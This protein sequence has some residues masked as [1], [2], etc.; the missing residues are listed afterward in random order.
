MQPNV[1]G[2]YFFSYDTDGQSLPGDLLLDRLGLAPIDNRLLE[3]QYSGMID[4][5]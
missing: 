2:I 4:G 5:L 1:N 3:D